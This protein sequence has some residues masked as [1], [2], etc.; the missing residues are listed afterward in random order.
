MTMLAVSVYWQMIV[1]GLILVIAVALDMLMRRF[2]ISAADGQDLRQEVLVKLWRQ[3]PQYDAGR[4]SFRSWMAG[5]T[6]YTL[7]KFFESEGRRRQRDASD[8]GLL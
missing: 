8:G 1:T 5:V 6:R 3:L 2:S 4:A 7:L